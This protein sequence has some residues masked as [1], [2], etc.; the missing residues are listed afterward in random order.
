[1]ASA[2]WVAPPVVVLLRGSAGEATTTTPVFTA[3]GVVAYFGFLQVYDS[4]TLLGGISAA[5]TLCV[6]VTFYAMLPLWA[7]LL[8]RVPC[9]SER[10]FLRSELLALAGLY[11]VGVAWVAITA[12]HARAPVAALLDVTRIKPWLYV[13]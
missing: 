7:M 6:E 9:R 13:L 3:H 8:R 10:G 11:V 1:L 12:P 5:W 4:Q 2:Y